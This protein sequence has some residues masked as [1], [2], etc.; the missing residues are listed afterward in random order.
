MLDVYEQ[1]KLKFLVDDY[2][3][4][5]YTPRDLTKWVLGLLRYDFESQDVFESWT[6]EANM[7]FRDRIID[8]AGKQRFDRIVEAVLKS[9]WSVTPNLSGS[10]F[11]SWAQV[12]SE[13]EE[14]ATAKKNDDG[15]KMVKMAAND[16]KELLARSLLLFER[17]VK[18]LN[19]QL[20]PEVLE[21]VARI[22]RVL[23]G[24]GG[25]LLLVGKS[26]VGRRSAVQLAAYANN[27]KLFSP[28]ISRF[29]NIKN[30]KID[31]KSILTSAGVEGVPVV[32]FIE[33]HQL[34]EAEFIEYLNSLLSSGEVPGL[35]SPEEID[36]LLAPLKDK[37]S[38]QGYFGSPFGFFVERV[39]ENLHIILSMDPRNELF[40]LRCESNPA[41]YIKCN[42]QWWDSWTPETFRSIPHMTIGKLLED[43]PNKDQIIKN[44][45]G[46][47][48]SCVHLGATPRQFT[49]LLNTY[50]KIYESH[51][52]QSL[53]QQSHLVAGLNKLND[54]AETVDKLS[55]EAE[56]KKLLLADKKEQV[57]QA[58]TEITKSMEKA[59]AQRQKM[60][61]LE[62]KLGEERVLMEGRKAEI[63]S[64]L[65]NI[66]PVLDSAKQ[67]VGSI[68]VSVDSF[69]SI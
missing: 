67:A 61:G 11:T 29:Y 28:N 63:E 58:V 21:H 37:L 23:S 60:V 12:T 17:E 36:P 35:Y 18:D 14:G 4:Y 47:H 9:Q 33:D 31:L 24:A 34:V 59:S 55:Q 54:A 52:K 40:Q 64:K 20:F 2:S 50:K 53:E 38:E 25:H 65:S 42:I 44:L 41:L 32:L 43:L 5:L 30:F 69:Y 1:T 7:L 51:R 68:N 46:I 6:Y 49:T 57:N 8:L 22:D 66:Q 3:H 45:I 19:I 13:T 26:G 16:Y 48:D 27:M 39:K 62:T 10:Y 15:K 56:Q